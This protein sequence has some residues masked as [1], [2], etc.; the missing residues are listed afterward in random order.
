MEST[1][2]TGGHSY[3][4]ARDWPVAGWRRKRILPGGVNPS[5]ERKDILGLDYC[6]AAM[7]PTRV[8]IV[9]STGGVAPSSEHGL[10]FGTYFTK[11]T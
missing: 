7:A 11:A 5:G 2:R 8:A 10:V 9:G 4:A 1:E 3:C 6:I